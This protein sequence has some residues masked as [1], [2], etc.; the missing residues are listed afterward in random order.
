MSSLGMPWLSNGFGVHAAAARDAVQRG[1]AAR[2]FV[3]LLDGHVEHGGDF[4]H[5]GAGAA[6]ARAV[7]AHVGY[8]HGARLLVGLE[9]DHLG[10]LAA[11]LDGAARLWVVCL[12]GKRVRNHFLNVGNVE[13]ARDGG[14]ARSGDGGFDV[15]MGAGFAQLGE[16]AARAFCLTRMMA[17]VARKHDLAGFGVERGD[18]RGR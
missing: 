16:Q 2:E 18:L 17:H 6:G 8:G 14:A 3:E 4:I 10:V 7:H 11:Q 5:E 12:D 1:A 9:E 13:D 15:R